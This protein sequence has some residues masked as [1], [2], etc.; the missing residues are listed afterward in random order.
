MY[1]ISPGIYGIASPALYLERVLEVY[2]RLFYLLQFSLILYS[3]SLV[4]YD[5]TNANDDIAE[6]Q[7]IKSITKADIG[8]SLNNARKVVGLLRPLQTILDIVVRSLVLGLNEKVLTK[9]LDVDKVDHEK[10][11]NGV[12]KKLR[13]NL[14]GVEQLLGL[15]VT[16][17]N[18]AS[19]VDKEV[20]AILKRPVTK[21][22]G[23]QL[24]ATSK[25]AIY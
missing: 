10:L 8:L 22:D 1:S 5:A 20:I 14:R 4:H 23:G 17:D 15:I 21:I 25:G 9:R 24:G 2:V 19:I 18:S 3:E 11:A 12:R 6:I 16:N 13:D 7:C